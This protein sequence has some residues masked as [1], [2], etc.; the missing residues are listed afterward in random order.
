M[1]ADRRSRKLALAR[2]IDSSPSNRA[3]IGFRPLAETRSDDPVP[4]RCDAPISAASIGIVP[5]PHI[6]SASGVVTLPSGAEQHRRRER[7]AQ[8]RF[9]QRLPISAPMQQLAGAVRAHRADVVQKAHDEQLSGRRGLLVLVPLHAANRYAVHAMRDRLGEAL[10]DGVAVIQLR[11]A[12][13]DAEIAR[14]IPARRIAPID[15]PRR[16]LELEKRLRAKLGDSHEDA[17][18]RPQPEI[19]R[20][21]RRAVPGPCDSALFHRGTNAELLE[22]RG[23]NAFDSGRGDGEATDRSSLAIVIAKTALHR[24]AGQQ[25]LRDAHLRRVAQFGEPHQ[26]IGLRHAA[27]LLAR[28]DRPRSGRD[29]S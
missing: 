14:S 22:L 6:G 11:L 10:R 27:P 9:G 8:R 19:R 4:A 20:R 12:A 1:I 24:G 23:A 28:R 18:R 2:A 29:A 15:L 17:A 25:I 21:E 5:D 3:M 13:C 16:S 26:Q 7:L